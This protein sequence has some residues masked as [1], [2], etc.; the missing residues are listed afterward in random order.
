MMSLA[1][2]SHSLINTWPKHT[3]LFCSKSGLHLI[4]I[5]PRQGTQTGMGCQDM[6]SSEATAVEMDVRGTG[7][8][9]LVEDVEEGEPEDTEMSRAPR[10]C[11]GLW[12]Q[13]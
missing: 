6:G 4:A 10:T 9:V 5:P 13:H 3:W 7:I 2:Y 1:G 12:L 8:Q 11:T